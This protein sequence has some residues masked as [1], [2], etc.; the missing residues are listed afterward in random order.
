[1]SAG[2]P[3]P[4]LPS[5]YKVERELGH[6]AVG[7]VFLALDTDTNRQ[8]VIKVLNA[9]HVFS[10][11]NGVMHISR[12]NAEFG[13]LRSCSHP[14]IIKV[15][16]FGEYN[17]R[18]FFTMEYLDGIPLSS[19]IPPRVL[20]EDEF[21]SGTN[22]EQ[23]VTKDVPI[24][25]PS[26]DRYID[27]LFQIAKALYYVHDRGLIHRD[28]K[29][30]NIFLTKDG[31]IKLLD[32]GLARPE[33][34]TL[35]LTVAMHAVGTAYYMAPEAIRNVPLDHLADVYSFGVLAFELLTRELP[36]SEGSRV[37]IAQK[38]AVAEIPSAKAKN[39]EIP[40][41]LDGVIKTCMQK[42]KDRRYQSMLEVISTF[43]K[44]VPKLSVDQD[45]KSK[46]DEQNDS[47]KVER[48]IQNER[49]DRRKEITT[50]LKTILIVFFISMFF[51][52]LWLTPIGTYS[53]IFLLRTLFWLRGPI[54][55]PKDVVIVALDDLTYQ[56][57]GVSTR[58]PF[59]RKYWAQV[60]EKIH[61]TKAKVVIMDGYIQ[62]E[63]DDETGDK[64]LE[65][66]VR[67]GPTVLMKW[68]EENKALPEE[69]RNETNKI[70][71]HNDSRFGKAALMEI[72]PFFLVH[73]NTVAKI[74]FSDENGETLDERIPIH[75]VLDKVNLTNLSEP[76]VNDFINFYGLPNRIT[77]YSMYEVIMGDY[78]FDNKIVLVGVK[79]M[80]RSDVPGAYDL[81]NTSGSFWG[82]Y[83]G[84]EIHATIAANLIDDSYIRGFALQYTTLVMMLYLGLLLMF[85]SNKKPISVL[86]YVTTGLIIWFVV[87]TI[88][89]LYF[90][91]FIPGVIFA[92]LN[93]FIICSV[94]WLIYGYKK[95][96]TLAHIKQITGNMF[97]DD[98]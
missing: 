13:A 30:D 24:V 51:T 21:L 98:R 17:K 23:P 28:L 75:A 95:D 89:F 56:H 47:L 49:E 97:C 62:P 14:N 50:S 42:E 41:W 57:F 18:P 65:E 79:S 87:T 16:D 61:A 45:L 92:S 64:A 53:N 84:V 96:I 74:S 67:K 33:Q 66:A 20:E 44:H 40:D 15:F 58:K 80:T 5:R 82:K 70:I 2:I 90:K 29:P 12:F 26:M 83:F 54:E 71:Y 7:D 1:M 81:F 94:A 25:Y 9:M 8:V 93:S 38:H 76:S 55:P 60:I 43:V 78:N 36:Y 32:F 39:P 59:P 72:V 34:T 91:L 68:E 6:G 73:L 35:K 88:A 48:H 4:K 22:D 31:E 69:E 77:S 27:Y 19:L 10:Q 46:L 85:L 11:Q 52:F 37:Q 86:I 3:T 63:T